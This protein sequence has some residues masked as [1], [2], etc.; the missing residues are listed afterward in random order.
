VPKCILIVDDH[1]LVRK[2]VRAFLESVDGYTCIE[3][4]DGLNALHKA[5]SSNPDLIILDYQMPRMNGLD[6]ARVLK[7]ILPTIP[8]VLFTMHKD[9][10]LPSEVKVLRIDAVVIKTESLDVL[11]ERIAQLLP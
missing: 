5:V 3:A 11:G 1:A 9:V 6:A 8:I 10:V 7:Q 2:Q 4:E